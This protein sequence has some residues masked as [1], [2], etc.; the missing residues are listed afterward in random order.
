[1]PLVATMLFGLC[2][3]TVSESAL[4]RAPVTATAVQQWQQLQPEV[5]AVGCSFAR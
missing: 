4:T 3:L 5:C 1:M 2:S